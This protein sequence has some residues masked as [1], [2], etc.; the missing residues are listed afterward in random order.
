MRVERTSPLYWGQLPKYVRGLGRLSGSVFNYAVAAVALLTM[1]AC[2]TSASDLESD[3]VYVDVKCEPYEN[4][5]QPDSITGVPDNPEGVRAYWEGKMVQI[6]WDPSP[7]TIHYNIFTD[8]N[9]TREADLCLVASNVTGTTYDLD[10]FAMFQSIPLAPLA[11]S[12][13]ARTPDPL[14]IEW[15]VP[16]RT[17]Q[18][19]VPFAVSACN[20]AGCSDVSQV[21]QT[22]ITSEVAQYLELQRSSTEGQAGGDSV[23]VNIPNDGECRDANLSDAFSYYYQTPNTPN[24]LACRYR[25]D[26][27]QPSAVYHYKVRACNARGCSRSSEEGAGTTE[28]VGTVDVPSA[29]TGIQGKRTGELTFGGSEIPEVIWNAV[30]GATYYEVYELHADLLD[31]QLNLDAEVSAPHIS[32]TD[33][34]PDHQDFSYGATYRVSACNKAGCSALSE[35]ANID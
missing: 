6:N 13:T 35:S 18:P 7:G 28:A 22:E 33:P 29:P 25:D 17:E 16:G 34:E 19:F 2:G 14:T 12:V 4:P 21:H 32:Y 24:T 10:G 26:G 9:Q 27:L 31:S 3:S 20:N 11:V 23:T 1:L 8:N 30:G 5:V 15:V